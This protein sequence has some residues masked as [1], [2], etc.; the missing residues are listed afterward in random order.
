V[1]QQGYTVGDVGIIVN[2]YS[3]CITEVKPHL[4]TYVYILTYLATQTSPNGWPQFLLIDK[5]EDIG[6]VGKLE[7]KASPHR[8][9]RESY[10]R[11]GVDSPVFLLVFNQVE[12]LQQT[13]CQRCPLYMG[14]S[15]LAFPFGPPS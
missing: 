11:E 10:Q 13:E 3:L 1:A 12:L 4:V 8:A 15:K 9:K 14:G 6:V 7:N 5:L 2:G